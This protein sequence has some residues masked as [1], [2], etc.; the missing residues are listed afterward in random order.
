MRA[1]YRE[2]LDNF[3]HDLIIMSDTVHNLMTLASKALLEGALQPAEEAVSL[4]EELDEVRARCED[5]AVSLLALENPMAKDLR[6]VISSIYIVEDYYR[7]GR[8]AQHIA[9]SAR[10]RHP[11]IVVPADILGFFEEYARLVLDM[12]LGLKDLLITRDPDLALRLTDDDDAVDDINQHLL[13]M[14]TQREWKGTVRQAVE[15][16]QLSRYY[17][18]FADHCASAAGRI[19]YLATGLDP[20]R[21]M[22][23]RDQ[24]QR[25]AE[26]E[27]RMA[28]LERQFHR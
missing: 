11:E 12:S 2:Q 25:E 28:E 18:R 13:R 9:T 10:R 26:L 20:E 1:A 24:E 22:H 16:S 6:Q 8:L 3:A 21:Y 14:L 15:T 27:A 4:R 19:I 17:E 5:R 23:K 7:M